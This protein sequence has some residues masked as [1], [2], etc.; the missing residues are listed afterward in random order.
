MVLNLLK[1]K[2]NV[3]VPLSCP[4]ASKPQQIVAAL[5]KPNGKPKVNLESLFCFF[6]WWSIL[7][8]QLKETDEFLCCMSNLIYFVFV[9]QQGKHK[10]PSGSR[11]RNTRESCQGGPSDQEVGATHFSGSTHSYQRYDSLP[12]SL[13]SMFVSLSLFLSVAES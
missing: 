5:P 2:E 1:V 7:K 13:S 10:K 6:C 11:S 12:S 3:N 9:W 8:V 4:A